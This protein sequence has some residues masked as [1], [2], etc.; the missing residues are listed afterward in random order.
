METIIAYSLFIFLVGGAIIGIFAVILL[1]RYVLHEMMLAS[2]TANHII[3]INTLSEANTLFQKIYQIKN[4]ILIC[5]KYPKSFFINLG[6]ELHNHI[7][8]EWHCDV[9][10]MSD[11]SSSTEYKFTNPIVFYWIAWKF[12]KLNKEVKKNVTQV[13]KNITSTYKCDNKTIEYVTDD[14]DFDNYL[15]KTISY[16]EPINTK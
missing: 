8:Y 5:E 16:I 6:T 4:N 7:H 3:N 1:H 14:F 10:K 2:S 12:D 11:I 9:L 15:Y 13:I